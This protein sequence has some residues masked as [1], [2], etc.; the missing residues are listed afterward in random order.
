MTT[1]LVY[2]VSYIRDIS[3]STNLV[4][5]HHKHA[6]QL[7]CTFLVKRDG[8]VG[9]DRLADM[10]IRLSKTEDLLFAHAYVLF[11]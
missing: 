9:E 4:L 5:V 11:Q 8:E 6:A 7:M 10:E 1:A 3:I 2:R